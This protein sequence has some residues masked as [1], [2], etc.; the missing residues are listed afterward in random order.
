MTKKLLDCKKHG[1]RWMRIR[2]AIFSWNEI[3]GG[4]ETGDS[5]TKV[6]V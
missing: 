3:T 1:R 2:R 4:V 6:G 5:V